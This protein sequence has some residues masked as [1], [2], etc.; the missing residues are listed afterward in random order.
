MEHSTGSTA[1]RR[2]KSRV[3]FGITR[4]FCQAGPLAWVSVTTQ[5]KSSRFHRKRFELFR[6][7]TPPFLRFFVCELLPPLHPGA[8]PAG[9]GGYIVL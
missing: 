9:I 4:R 6:R 1:E 2:R 5:G 7:P 3:I 8:V